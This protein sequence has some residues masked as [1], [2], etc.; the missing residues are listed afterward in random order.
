MD[1]KHDPIV[2]GRNLKVVHPLTDNVVN[3]R[4]ISFWKDSANNTEGVSVDI[5]IGDHME[6]CGVHARKGFLDEPCEVSDNDK[7]R[8]D[9]K[10]KFAKSVKDTLEFLEKSGRL[11]LN[12]ESIFMLELIYIV[13]NCKICDII[14]GVAC[15]E[16]TPDFVLPCP[17]CK[18]DRYVCIDH[19]LDTILY[20]KQNMEDIKATYSIFQCS[21]CGDIFGSMTIGN[22]SGTIEPCPHCL[23][24]LGSYRIKHCDIGFLF[25]KSNEEGKRAL[26][27]E[28]TK[29]E[30]YYDKS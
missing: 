3:S 30:T 1:M 17:N 25:E 6:I 13:F 26:N 12:P 16:S 27:R 21:D 2:I 19:R 4:I 8:I 10:V 20:K 18:S 22:P 14:Y 9:K 15:P 24:V 28:I 7:N 23:S 5:Y 11:N 29:M